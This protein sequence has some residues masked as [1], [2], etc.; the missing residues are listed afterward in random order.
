MSPATLVTRPLA[1]ADGVAVGDAR[2][3]N[4]VVRRP[5]SAYRIAL[6]ARDRVPAVLAYVAAAASLSVTV[7]RLPQLLDAAYRASDAPATSIIAGALNAGHGPQYLPTQ[8]SVAVIWLDQLLGRIPLGRALELWTGP[9]LTAAAIGLILRAA[10]LS[11]GPGS[12]RRTA[13][14]VAVMPPVVLWPLLF[15]DAHVTTFVGM[16]MLSWHLA[17]GLR[18]DRNPVRSVA[19]GVL[20]GVL[21]VSDPQLA[22][23]GLV[24]YLFAMMIIWRRQ[25]GG[26]IG[27]AVVTV[28]SAAGGVTLTLGI[29]TL[30]GIHVI[31]I[32]PQQQGLLANVTHGAATAVA[33]IGSVVT[34][35]W[36]GSGFVPLDAVLALAGLIGAGAALVVGVRAVRRSHAAAGGTIS[37]R[38]GF[39]IYWLTAI[40]CL[41][42]AFLL[43]GYGFAAVNGYYLVPCYF[44]VAALVATGGSRL[45]HRRGGRTARVRVAGTVMVAVVFSAF[46]VNAAVATATIDPNDFNGNMAPPQAGA[47]LPVLAAHHLTRGYAGYWEAYDLDWQAS[48]KVAI[49]P[50]VGAPVGCAGPAG[51]LCPYPFA[52]QGEYRPA[53]G[54][55][56]IITPGSSD[57]CVPALPPR[58]LFG[59]PTAVYHSGPYTVSVYAYDVASRFASLGHLFC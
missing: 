15:P 31:E 13:L 3:A 57:R 52:P 16:G 54:P 9:L 30:Q 23:A 56:F 41:V 29:M 5:V 24:P 53:T 58:S 46:A 21:A 2:A 48:G 6:S 10:A 33:M 27:T 26:P 45:L 4:G 49:W 35:S 19:V 1:T 22:V 11:G 14:I 59:T 43:L 17:L 34:A 18:G 32:Y 51:G 25:R 42:G 37:V 12:A 28:A 40:A 7:A 39:R 50:V 44:A 20:C 8:T 36:F 38:D 47:L 55:T